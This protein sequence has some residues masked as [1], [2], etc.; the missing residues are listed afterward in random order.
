MNYTILSTEI[1]D[2][3][4]HQET[5]GRSDA[6]TALGGCSDNGTDKGLG[7]WTYQIEVRVTNDDGE[8]RDFTIAFQ[9]MERRDG[10]RNYSGYEIVAAADNSYDADQSQ[11]LLT[12]CDNDSRVLD[13]L[14][15]LASAA[16]K[17]EYL[18]LISEREQE[19][20]ER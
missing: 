9:P 3:K 5:F 8:T 16:A 12:F 14:Q 4:W 1:F 17:A 18:Q 15:F 13:E 2:A 20:N 11:A 10:L 19:D 6:L 7:D